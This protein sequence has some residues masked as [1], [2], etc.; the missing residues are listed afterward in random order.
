MAFS[1]QGEPNSDTGLRDET[2]VKTGVAA[3]NAEASARMKGCL[4]DASG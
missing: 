4:A 3:V 2:T 1:S